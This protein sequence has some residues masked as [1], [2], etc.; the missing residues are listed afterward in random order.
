MN[1]NLTVV[2]RNV[3][4]ILMNRV[5]MGIS[6]ESWSDE[7][8]YREIKTSYLIIKEQLREL[9]GDI[10]ELSADELEELGFKKWEEE[11]ELYLIPLWAFDLIPDGTELE[12]IDGDKAI[13]GK[14]EID[15]GTLFGCIAW[16]FKPKYN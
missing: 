12:C 5:Q 16:G 13:K 4:K 8:S 9:I 14:D 6:Y 15:L 7:L 3:G 11:S 2:M 1:K 10:T